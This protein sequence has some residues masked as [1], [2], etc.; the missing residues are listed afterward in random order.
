MIVDL[1]KV[2]TRTAEYNTM[3][4]T[5]LKVA[6]ECT[7]LA[8]V[9]IK[10]VTKHEDYRPSN[11]KLIEEMGDVIFRIYVAARKMKVDNEVFARVEAKAKQLDVWMDE[12]KFK[13]GV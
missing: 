1:E 12:Q 2:I 5:L 7:E 8:E 6:E 11:D 13:G 3:D 9:M 10:R 4:K